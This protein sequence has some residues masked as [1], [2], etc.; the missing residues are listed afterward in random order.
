M[1]YPNSEFYLK[2]EMAYR[3]PIGQPKPFSDK[4]SLFKEIEKLLDSPVEETEYITIV[5][6]PPKDLTKEV[7][8]RFLDLGIEIRDTDYGFILKKSLYPPFEVFTTPGTLM[9]K[10]L[11]LGQ[12]KAKKIL[13]KGFLEC[14][15]QIRL[16]EWRRRNQ[17]YRNPSVLFI[18]YSYVY[19]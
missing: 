15:H 10:V 12:G 13:W 17:K 6:S 1:F 3:T 14:K 8:K 7:I 5:H 2:Y 4:A 11:S 19:D 16:N 9:E 18:K